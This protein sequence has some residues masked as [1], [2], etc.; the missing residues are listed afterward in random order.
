MTP[1]VAAAA[2]LALAA[3]L[4]TGRL[5]LRWRRSRLIGAGSAARADTDTDASTDA[6]ARA[7]W[8]ALLGLQPVLAALLWF[9]LF[10]PHAARDETTL[11]L[12]TA[13]TTPAA[14]AALPPGARL[15]ALPEAPALPGVARTP[16]LATALRQ[17]DAARLHVLGTG[18]VARD[19][20]AVAGRPLRFD[21]GALPRGL[22]G[23]WRDQAAIVGLPFRVAGDTEALAG[24]RADLLDPAGRVL[25]SE[26]IDRDGRFALLGSAPVTGTLV[27]ALRLRDA[28]GAV[29]QSADL[30]MQ[31]G[32]GTRPRLLL[33]AG[34]PGPELKYLR[35]W[36]VD[37]GLDL[38]VRIALGAGVALAQGAPRLDPAS[39]R[40]LDVALL[41]DRAWR[42]L[43]GAS[44]AALL[45][46]VHEGL[47]VLVRL[48]G[49]V[50][51]AERERWRALGFAIES[52][53]LPETVQ[54][55]GTPAGAG[56][57]A[58]ALRA[59]D[60]A[61]PPAPSRQALRVRG[62]NLQPLLADAAGEP[63]ATWRA[64]G[65]GRL[66]LAWFGDSYR[67][68]LAGAA[69]QHAQLWSGVLGTLARARAAAP[70]WL[71]DAPARVGQRLLLCAPVAGLRLDDPDG[72][73]IPLH[74]EPRGD[75]HCALAW[76]Q[77]AGWHHAHA[78]DGAADILV[79]GEA[80]LPGLAARADRDATRALA[81]QPRTPVESAR[82]DAADGSPRR[83]R[84]PWFL[85]WLLACALAWQLERRLLRM[86]HAAPG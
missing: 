70:P 80:A 7:A 40:A 61:D 83:P 59:P 23:L 38:Q 45:Q 71:E 20:D 47:G 76:P 42:G 26:A 46:A 5:A 3:A 18:L 68:V 33:L 72:A 25:A 55:P 84:W 19:R 4:A 11:V 66:G 63:L 12:A 6:G 75:A 36:A 79:L 44:R 85:G 53:D 22:V 29:V 73:A 14:I 10:P 64:Q 51:G 39:L 60:A 21:A 50:D 2:V 1:V 54:L 41:D 24:G 37:A 34:G 17:R 62:P 77:R 49:P 30:P 13:A 65:R 35:R 16:D 74:E 43:D 32:E 15:L 9:T 8:V 52:A 86:A 31:V 69:R 57:A 82:R 67:L 81:A 56:A 28:R 78:G 27:F 58:D 48:T